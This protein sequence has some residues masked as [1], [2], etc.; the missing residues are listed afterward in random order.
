MSSW[1]SKR[2]CFKGTKKLNLKNQTSLIKINTEKM[3]HNEIMSS[4]SCLL[5]TEMKSFSSSI[6]QD[7]AA[8]TVNN[9]LFLMKKLSSNASGLE[10]QELD[11]LVNCVEVRL[12]C[13]LYTT[14]AELQKRMNMQK[15]KALINKISRI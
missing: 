14:V 11:Q 1:T 4:T 12:N 13:L 7:M 2:S 3:K 5:V 9:G 15:L 6:M 8:K 10:S